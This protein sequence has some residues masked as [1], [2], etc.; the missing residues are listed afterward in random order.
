MRK[1]LQPRHLT[2]QGFQ[3]D[4]L[5]Y[6]RHRQNTHLTIKITAFQLTET[7]MGSQTLIYLWMLQIFHDGKFSKG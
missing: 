3:I 2:R 5:Q 6:S 7:K 1:K 4:M